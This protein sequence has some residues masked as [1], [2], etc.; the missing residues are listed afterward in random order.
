MALSRCAKNFL[1]YTPSLLY[2]ETHPKRAFL[3]VSPISPATVQDAIDA[4][5]TL[6]ASLRRLKAAH[7]AGMLGANLGK[8]KAALNY[9]KRIKSDYPDAAEADLVDVQIGR[10]ENL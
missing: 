8:N 2:F 6:L 1:S 10:L 7:K 9:F 3:D 5:I 4:H